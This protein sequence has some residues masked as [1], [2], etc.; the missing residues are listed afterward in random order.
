MGDPEDLKVSN[1]QLISELIADELLH[2]TGC[3]CIPRQR[4]VEVHDWSRASCRRRL[5][6]NLSASEQEQIPSPVMANRLGI[7][8]V[9]FFLASMTWS[10]LLRE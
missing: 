2:M 10:M 5:L 8:H 9:F 1:L 7:S 4:R 3:N 6:C